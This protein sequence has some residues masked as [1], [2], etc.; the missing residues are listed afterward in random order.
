[1]GAESFLTLQIVDFAEGVDDRVAAL[2]T[3]GTGIT[4]TYNDGAGTL[5]IA[6]SSTGIGGSTGSTDNTVLRADGTG[7]AT[8]QDSTFCIPDIYTASPNN[9]VNH[10]SLQAVGATTNASSSFVPKGSGAFSL[11]VPDGTSTGGNARGANAV[12]LSIG[13][14]T[15]ADYVASGAR[16]V[17][18]GRGRASGQDSIATGNCT[19]SGQYAVC[20]GDGST[21]NGASGARAIVLNGRYNAASGDDSCAGGQSIIASGASSFGIGSDNTASGFA[22][23]ASGALSRAD[24]Y[25]MRAHGSGCFAARGDAQK[26]TFVLRQKTTTATPVNLA[27]DGSSTRLIVNTGEILSFVAHITGSKS[28]GTAIASFIRRGVIK[29][30]SNTTSLV[31]AIQT[32]GT[33]IEDN[34]STD[35]AITADDTNEALQ[36][37]VTG[38][39][40]ETW[41]WV[42]VVEAVDLAF[43]T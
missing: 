24:R 27:L 2:L 30:I 39:A 4:I 21:G 22:S 26:A 32:I 37:A 36:I 25:S 1:M 19:A 28:D 42:A 13:S 11:A 29:R 41:R 15:G 17:V 38:I 5:T 40:G 33:D 14:R 20:F 9:T 34:A 18:L 6:A 7:G 3:A 16:A 43:G 8:L 10:A 23:F 12:D 31:G 35:V